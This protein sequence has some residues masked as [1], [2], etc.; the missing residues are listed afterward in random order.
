MNKVQWREHR[1]ALAGVLIGFST[2]MNT[3]IAFFL[4]PN[5]H[6][7]R[8]AL[9]LADMALSAGLLLTIFTRARKGQETGHRKTQDA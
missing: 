6:G 4:P 2:G 1:K 7:N 3:Y 8:V 5:M 9:F